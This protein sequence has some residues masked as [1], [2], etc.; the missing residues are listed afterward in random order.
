ME[1]AS[2]IQA[3]HRLV[4]QRF[5]LQNR[6]SNILSAC[7]LNPVRE[8]LSS[9]EKLKT[10][11]ELPRDEVARMQLRV[12]AGQIRAL[13]ASIDELES[14]IHWARTAHYPKRRASRCR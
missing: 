10:L 12:I 2:L 9:E 8:A 11:L 3:L 5:A 1:T 7:G 13:N 14:S 4:E 6:A